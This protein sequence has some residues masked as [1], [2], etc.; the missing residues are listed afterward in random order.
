MCDF[1]PGD[2]V[3]CVDDSRRNPDFGWH[4]TVKRGLVYTVAA[5]GPPPFRLGRH[6]VSVFILGAPNICPLDRVDIGYLPDRFRKVQRRKTDLSIESFLT[7]RPGF[8]EPRRVT[9]PTRKRERA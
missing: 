4:G 9:T 6:S 8:E 5:V 7:I 2:E 1:K 3:V